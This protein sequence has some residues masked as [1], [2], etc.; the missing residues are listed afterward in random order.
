MK[1]LIIIGAGSFAKIV[2]EYALLCS[3]YNVKWNIKGFI[4][5]NIDSMKDEID[6]PDIIS[7]ID[8][9]EVQ[10]DD[11]FICSYV[12]PADR[13]RSVETISGKGGSFITIIHPSANINRRSIIGEGTII[14]AFTTLSV[15]TIIRN[16]VIIQDHCN[17]GHDSSIGNYSHLYVNCTVSGLNQIGN[18]ATIY[19]STTLYPKKRIGDKSVVGAGSVVMRN[20]KDG[21]VV[22]GN[23]AKKME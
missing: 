10:E 17:I 2:Y 21:T 4:D 23:P 22:I 3:D 20:V 16:H 5:P 15:N 13:A 19:T 14:G 1:N 8:D 7:T 9:Y 12:N 6:Y 18:Q 11:I